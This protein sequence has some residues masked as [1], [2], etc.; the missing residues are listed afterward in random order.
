VGGTNTDAVLMD[1]AELVAAVKL[2]TSA[3][4]TSGITSAL[5]QLLVELPAGGQVDAVMVGTTHFTNALLE[6]RN[7]APT[8]VVR[9]SL[10]A[11][12]L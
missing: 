9:L 11:T 10:P 1:G 4:V 3:D 12:Q 5:T 2:P 7:L 8:A 6:R